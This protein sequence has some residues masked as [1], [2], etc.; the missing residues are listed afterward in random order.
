M[1]NIG[2]IMIVSLISTIL[3]EIISGLILGVRKGLDILNILL[4]NLLTNPLVVSI[5][6][7]IN[8]AYGLKIKY[9]VLIILE[10]LV[11]IIEGL[12]YK[13]Y[14]SYRKIDLIIFSLLLNGCSYFIG[15]IINSIIW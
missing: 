15:N 2:L 7:Y 12:I 11:V 9:I 10:V 3:L 6:Y 13:K 14:F 8:L 5:S 1:M 4:V